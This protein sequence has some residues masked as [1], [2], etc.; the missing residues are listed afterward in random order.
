MKPWYHRQAPRFECTACGAC[1]L[2]NGEEYV[3]LAAGEDETIRAHLGLTPEW[4]RRRYLI[5]MTNGELALRMT[6]ANTCSFLQDDGRCAVYEVRPV[7]CRSYPFWPE[8]LIS[9]E[10]WRAESL[11]CEGI[12]RG[13]R[14]SLDTIKAALKA[15]A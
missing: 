11:R 10:T 1:C 9:E 5:R 12:D 2:G 13:Q 7:Q 8:L 4:F 3:F 14:V 15:G 6:A